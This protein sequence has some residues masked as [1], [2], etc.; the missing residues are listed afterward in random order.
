MYRR[1][2][3]RR[4][5]SDYV[6]LDNIATNEASCCENQHLTDVLRYVILVT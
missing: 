5:R 2:A 3:A 4:E 1:P 6:S